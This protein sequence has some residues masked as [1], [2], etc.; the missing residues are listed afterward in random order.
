MVCVK[1]V[2]FEWRYKRYASPFGCRSRVNRTL[3]GSKN[4]LLQNEARCTTF[5]VKMSFICVRMK[6]D[7]RIK[8]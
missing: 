1:M 8:G 6:N 7:F 5:P 3:P 4:P 2:N